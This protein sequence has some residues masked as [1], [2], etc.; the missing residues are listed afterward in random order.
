MPADNGVQAA[1]SATHDMFIV[2]VASPSPVD[3]ESELPGEGWQRVCS[4]PCDKALP[5]GHSYRVGGAG[6]RPSSAFAL[7]PGAHVT[8]Q[9][10]PVS[11]ASRVGPI[12]VTVAGGIAL[13]PVVGV[14]VLLVVGVVV[15]AVVFCPLVGVI[16]SQGNGNGNS[17]YVSCIGALASS[18]TPSYASPLVWVPA[19][20][21]SV[22][23]AGG[24]TWLATSHGTSVTQSA[25]AP[26][27]PVPI[28]AVPEMWR[29]DPAEVASR[30]LA[31]AAATMNLID[32]RF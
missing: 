8:M 28:S 9:V 21:G 5:A 7:E 20:A 24:I 31:P 10:E 2:H 30:G 1:A 4:S 29:M 19:I 32:Y 27:L 17:A 16:A 23:L 22:A 18:F 13:A 14:T 3:L 25:P 6:V 11:S 12:L 15:G 26:P